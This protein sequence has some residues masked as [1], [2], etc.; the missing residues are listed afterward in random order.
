MFHYFWILLNRMPQRVIPVINYLL[1]WSCPHKKAYWIGV[2]TNDIPLVG[3]DFTVLA[4]WFW[5][6]EIISY[7][8]QTTGI[9]A[10]A[11][12]IYLTWLKIIIARKEIKRIEND[13]LPRND[14]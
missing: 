2:L 9:V 1:D 14:G 8:G 7:I 3:F 5:H 4:V 11:A 6:P 10:G 12:G 13:T